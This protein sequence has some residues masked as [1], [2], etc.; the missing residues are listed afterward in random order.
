MEVLIKHWKR[1]K[2]GKDE[3]TIY[4]TAYEFV[5]DLSKGDIVE[6]LILAE[7]VYDQNEKTH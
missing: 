3:D 1:W 5:E 7:S 2:K 4:D 6:L